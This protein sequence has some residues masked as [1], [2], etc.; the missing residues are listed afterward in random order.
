M[1][2]SLLAFWSHFW[3]TWGYAI[4]SKFKSD[5]KCHRCDANI[6]SYRKRAIAI[7]FLPHNCWCDEWC[8]PAMQ[9][10]AKRWNYKS[11]R[12]ESCSLEQFKTHFLLIN[13]NLNYDDT[14]SS[15][16]TTNSLHTARITKYFQKK[17]NRTTH[18][19][20]SSYGDTRHSAHTVISHVQ[21]KMLI[22]R[23]QCILAPEARAQIIHS[24]MQSVGS[25]K[26][27]LLT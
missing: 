5:L 24:L 7:A 21:L 3:T 26:K 15:T 4:V 22:A 16:C 19:P 20:Q 6:N 9:I 17:S 23:V 25:W 18:I 13:M 1:Q 27:I 12:S 14:F 11:I 8:W 10:A 2:H